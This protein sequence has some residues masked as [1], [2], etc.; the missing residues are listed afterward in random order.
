VRGNTPSA[1]DSR[2]SF[3]LK[4]SMAA[5][6]DDGSGQTSPVGFPPAFGHGTLVAGV[7]HAVAPL[8]RIVPIRAFDP[9]G[10]TTIFKLAEA[11]YRGSDLGVNV[12]NLSFSTTEISK[13]LQLAAT[14]AQAKGVALVASV[15]NENRDVPGTY[16]ATYGMVCAVAATDF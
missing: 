14:Y 2:L 12:L 8:A 16:P 7:L 3:L 11:I 9:S 6:L 1:M 5:L 4:Q 15:G 13:T 10:N